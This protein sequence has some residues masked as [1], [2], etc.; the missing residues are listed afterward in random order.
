MK[1]EPRISYGTTPTVFD[2]TIAQRPWAVSERSV[3]GSGRAAS[4]TPETYIIRREFLIGLTL[5]FYESQWAGV[6]AWLAWCHDNASGPFTFYPDRAS[7][8]TSYQMYLEHPDVNDDVAPV[9]GEYPGT[10]ELPVTLRSS[11]ST[12]FATAY[13]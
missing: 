10:Y 7:L 12:R 13:N 1:Q 8:G 4:G 2:F 3:G 9:R 6:A 5:R 11:N